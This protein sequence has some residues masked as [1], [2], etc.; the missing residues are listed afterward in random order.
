MKLHFPEEIC[1]ERRS[2][3]AC[4]KCRDCKFGGSEWAWS[5]PASDAECR[6]WCDRARRC[7]NCP[8]CNE[9]DCGW[10]PYGLDKSLAK[11]SDGER[12]VFNA[13]YVIS[14]VAFVLF[15]FYVMFWR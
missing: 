9:H 3:M 8:S 10:Y 6:A 5:K 15:L 12:T 11:L 13:I 14:T 7:G 1:V 2:S 4:P